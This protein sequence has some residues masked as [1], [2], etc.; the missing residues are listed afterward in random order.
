MKDNAFKV[1]AC[2]ILCWAA[3]LLMSSVHPLSEANTKSLKITYA[4]D[5]AVNGS[6]R[7]FRSRSTGLEVT[8]KTRITCMT[9]GLKRIC[10][11]E[12]PPPAANSR[13]VWAEF[14]GIGPARSG[15][16]ALL[17]MLKEH[18]HIQVGDPG[19]QNIDC[20]PGS[21]LYFFSKD[22]LFE[23]G[24]E[25]YKGF[26]APRKP[27]VKIA[28]EKTPKYSSHPLVPYRIRALLGPKVKLIFTIRDPL[29]ALLS[30]YRIRHREDGEPIGVYFRELLRIQ[31]VY[32]K[33]VQDAMDNVQRL[34]GER[35]KTLYETPRWG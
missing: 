16:S 22:Q 30:L 25:F 12:S 8:P 20:C 17:W 7:A 28:G 32:D 6:H 9:V 4:C 18:P 29:E 24:L 27:N 23:K 13:E 34:V 11:E 3:I 15:S 35:S 14:I 1:V 19:L 33:C 5:E 21:E 10:I 26:F 2:I 31:K